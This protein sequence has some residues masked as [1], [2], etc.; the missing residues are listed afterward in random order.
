MLCALRIFHY[1]QPI[2][3]NEGVEEYKGKGAC[4]QEFGGGLVGMAL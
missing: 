2:S 1:P 4:T 3:H